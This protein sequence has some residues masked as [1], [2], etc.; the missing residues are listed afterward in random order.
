MED[1]PIIHPNGAKAARAGRFDVDY[2]S[3]TRE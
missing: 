2:A 3:G 1:G